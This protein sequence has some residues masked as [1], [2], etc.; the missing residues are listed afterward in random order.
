M[1]MRFTGFIGDII[2]LDHILANVHPSATKPSRTAPRAIKQ[3]NVFF[4]L[5]R[6]PHPPP[7]KKKRNGE[8]D[9]PSQTT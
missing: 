2:S 5:Q 3:R 7:P 8:I 4:L 1:L 6:T 9:R